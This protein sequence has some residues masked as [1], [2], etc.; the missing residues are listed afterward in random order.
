MDNDHGKKDA[1][2]WQVLCTHIPV[3]YWFNGISMN[4][5]SHISGAWTKPLFSLWSFDWYIVVWGICVKTEHS[6]FQTFSFSKR[7]GRLKVR[8]INLSPVFNV[9]MCRIEHCRSNPYG[10]CATNEWVLEFM[11]YSQLSMVWYMGKAGTKYEFEVSDCSNWL[12]EG[13]ECKTKLQLQITVHSKF[14]NSK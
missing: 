12:H 7:V 2:K 3:L 13:G 1:P 4:Q 8:H 9:T 11:L 5:H 14:C 10:I 6:L